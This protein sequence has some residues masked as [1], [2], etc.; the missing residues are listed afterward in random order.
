[1]TTLEKCKMLVYRFARY[2][3]IDWNHQL[4]STT[5]F[6]D[7]AEKIMSKTPKSRGM[8]RKK[9]SSM[10]KQALAYPRELLS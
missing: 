9:S 10:K 2:W 3:I 7:K 4:Q 1:M 5:L 6:K 8:K